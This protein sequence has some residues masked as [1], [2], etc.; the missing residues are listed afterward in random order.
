LSEQVVDMLKNPMDFDAPGWTANASLPGGDI[1]NAD[2]ASF[3]DSCRRQYPWLDDEVLKDY[4]RN[5]G[6]EIE[7]MLSGRRCMA[8]LGDNFGGGL[9]ECEV[10]YLIK[11]EWA[12]LPEDI[13]WRRTKKGLKVSQATEINLQTFMSHFR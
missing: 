8:D 4:A 1:D 6:T 7:I 3:L 9:N 10:R 5:Y 11:Y 12:E 13:L 2:F